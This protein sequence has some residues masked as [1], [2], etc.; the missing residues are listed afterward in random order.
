MNPSTSRAQHAHNSKHP[1]RVEINLVA[2]ELVVKYGGMI[3]KD[4]IEF[5]AN[6]ADAED[7]YQRSVEILLTKAPTIDPEELVP[8]LR[9]VVKREARDI[10]RR[11][12]QQDLSL[13]EEHA[14]SIA[15]TNPSPES[16]AES[17]AVLEISAEAIS[18]L[19]PDQIKCVMAQNEGLEY[20]EIAEATGFS[21]RKVSRCLANARVAFARNVEAI[22][23]GSECERVEP[24]LHKL[25]DGDAAAAIE[26]RPHLR[27]C[28]AC[29]ARL[30]EYENAPRRIAVLFPP[31]LVLVGPSNSG[32]LARFADWWQSLGDRIWAHSFGADRWIEASAVKKVGAVAALTATAAGGGVAVHEASESRDSGASTRAEERADATASRPTQLF[33]T[34]QVSRPKRHKR[35]KAD[36]LKKV[37]SVGPARSAV[38]TPPP[39]A[40]GENNQID[41]GSAEF[42]PEARGNQ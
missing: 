40:A 7:A 10:A 31:A 34:V 29:R 22:T 32:L 16:M 6:S 9:T 25:L 39:A 12:H 38:P 35:K 5:S 15:A 33:D 28:L 19:S 36:T 18:K 30:R 37:P 24:L 26:V 41:D 8:W 17:F 2:S 4:A 3:L 13:N 42:L 21:K 11:H 1:D 20:E 14:D 27:H 23:A